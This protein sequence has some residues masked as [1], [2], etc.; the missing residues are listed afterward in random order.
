MSMN[1]DVGMNVSEQCTTSLWNLGTNQNLQLHVLHFYPCSSS[2]IHRKFFTDYINLHSKQSVGNGPYPYVN[3]QP[4]NYICI[5]PAHVC[6]RLM[7]VY[8]TPPSNPPNIRKIVE[9]ETTSTHINTR[10]QENPVMVRHIN[11]RIQDNPV[12]VYVFQYTLAVLN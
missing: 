3:L 4:I 2:C 7:Y 12:L 8:P 11:T 5:S 1:Y 6:R 10:I 9:M